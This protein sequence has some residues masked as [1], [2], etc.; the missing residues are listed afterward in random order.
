MKIDLRPQG[1]GA[2]C[3]AAFFRLRK[4]KNW[5]QARIIAD[6]AAA[7]Y[8]APTDK[9][10]RVFEAANGFM[11]LGFPNRRSRNKG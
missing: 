2:R 10:A 3:A 11:I 8:F 5:K 1:K 9:L 7:F 6:I 4:P